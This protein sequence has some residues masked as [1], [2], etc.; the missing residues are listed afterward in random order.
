M[1]GIT[2]LRSADSTASSDRL[3]I[4]VVLFLIGLVFPLMIHVGPIRLTLYR[5]LLLLGLIPFLIRW[6]SSGAGP[7]RLAD[8]CMMLIGLWAAVS[9]TVQLGAESA[10]EPVG[11]H[12][13]ETWGAYFLARCLI[14]S[15]E[16]FRRVAV[17]LF[18]IVIGLLPFL[19]YENLTGRSMILEFINS[20]GQ[21]YSPAYKEPRLGFERAQGPFQH[22]ILLGVFCG[23][24]VSLAYYVVAHGRRPMGRVLRTLLVV[25]AAFTGLSSGPLAGISVQLILIGW[26]R[27]FRRYR[28]RWWGFG[29]LFALGYVI[30]DLISNRTPLVVLVY[31]LSFNAD[32]AYDRFKIFEWGWKDVMKHPV[33]GNAGGEWENVWYMSQSVDMFWLLNA[34]THGLPVGA[35]Y[36]LAFF[37]IF[38]AVARRELSDPRLRDYRMGFLG[39]MVGMFIA[40]WAVHF[41]NETYVLMMFLMGSGVWLL[42]HEESPSAPKS[43][44]TPPAQPA[45]RRTILG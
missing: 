37:L 31:Y 24:T 9:W 1:D 14:R 11:I 5:I 6:L 29:G 15:P 27:V 30:V 13:V 17:I 19:I 40:G 4:L 41:W 43:A 39:A 36:L 12:I 42:D 34:M 8:V 28:H 45:R 23:A 10:I 16:A 18:W 22:P 32:T 3:S 38:V 35:L 21:T 2:R 44:P 33:F 7:I 26:D 20:L 25:F